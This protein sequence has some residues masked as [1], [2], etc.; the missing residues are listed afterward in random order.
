MVGILMGEVRFERGVLSW[1]GGVSEQP[2]F[3]SFDPRT[4]RWVTMA[5]NYWRLPSRYTD[6]VG[7][8][9]D[10]RLLNTALPELRDYQK[11]AQAAWW[12]TRRGIIV[13]PTGTGK[14][15]V[16]LSLIARSKVSTLIVAPVR[17]LMY[18]WHRRIQAGL[19]YEAGLLGD[20]VRDLRE[21]T[22]TTYA[23]A[24]IHMERLGDRFKLLVFDECHHLPGPVL[25][26]AARMSCAPWRLGLTATPE[27]SEPR[28]AEL[29]DLIGPIRYCMP[30]SAARGV[31][32][33][34]YDV[35][36]IPIFLSKDEQAR[37]DRCLEIMRTFRENWVKTGKRFDWAQ[38]CAS[39]AISGPAREA[40]RAYHLRTSIENRAHEKLRILEDIFQLHPRVP[41]LVFVGSN[42]MACDISLQFLIPALLSF[43]Q[44][45]E[46]AEIL[47]RF[48]AG[49]YPAMVVN[50]VLDEGVDLPA[51]K[52]AVVLG[53]QASRRQAKQRLGRILRPCQGR[54]AILYE[55]VCARTGEVRRSQIRR[56]TDAYEG[57]RRCDAQFLHAD[58]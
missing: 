2:D 1:C 34:D 52:V 58:H 57:T 18:Q 35:F 48:E 47:R 13:L 31:H 28:Q 11:E 14:T 5:S 7:R 17:D 6:G 27:C 45:S 4:G 10:L 33:A 43:S 3:W 29:V 24:A 54:R 55:V 32:L 21:I 15:E 41:T 26:D 19:G 39:S 12:S 20:R 30:L 16:A 42:Q 46:R 38:M 56:R 9:F 40:L 51:A 53:G 36:R 25:G 22:C 37:Y 23:S 50:R 49:D 8:W 44:K